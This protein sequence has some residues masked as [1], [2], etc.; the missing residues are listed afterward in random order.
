MLPVSRW[1]EIGRVNAVTSILNECMTKGGGCHKTAETEDNRHCYVTFYF[2]DYE[3]IPGIVAASD[4]ILRLQS[5]CT[6]KVW[7]CVFNSEFLMCSFYG[8]RLIGIK[9][10]FFI[11]LYCLHKLPH[12]LCISKG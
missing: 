7:N 2:R 1:S 10:F 3:L 12:H 8:K 11:L 6:S 9:C 4:V 5:T